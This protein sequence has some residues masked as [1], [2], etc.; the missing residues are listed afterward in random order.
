[1]ARSWALASSQGLDEAVALANGT[2]YGLVTYAYT[3]DLRDSLRSLANT[4]S[5]AASPSIR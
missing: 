3:R 1:M 4:S 5:Q 2:E